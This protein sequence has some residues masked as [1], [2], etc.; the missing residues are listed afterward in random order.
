MPHIHNL[1]FKDEKEVIQFIRDNMT[2]KPWLVQ[3]RKDSKLL[4]ALVLGEDFK[5]VLIKKIEQL[6]SQPRSIARKRYSKDIRD[7]FERVMQPRDNIF[8][9]SGGS[10]H[11][12]VD[13]TKQKERFIETLAKFKGQKGIKKYLADNYFEMV[14]TD[15]NGLIFLEYIDDQKIFPTYKSIHDIRYYV[16]DGQLL[17]VLLFEPKNVTMQGNATTFKRWRV[18]DQEKD[19]SILQSG[20]TFR[21]EEE[22]TFEHPFGEIPGVIL[23]DRTKTGSE[24][25]YSPLFSI[26]PLS[27]DYARDKSIKT[28]YK[29]QHGF[30]LHWRYSQPC[31]HCHGSGKTGEDTC[32]VCDGKGRIL[33][34]DVTDIIEVDLPEDKEDAIVAPNL[35]GFIQP[36]LETWRQYNTDM[37]QDE[38]R[39]EDTMWGTHR[40]REGSG[41]ET[42]TGRFIDIQPVKN[43]LDKMSDTVELIHNQLGDWVINWLFGAPQEEDMYHFAYGRRFIIESAD[44]AMERYIEAMKDGANNTVLDKLLDEYLETNFQN[45]P[46]M[47]A[48]VTKKRNVEPYLHQTI[49]QV[50]I[51]FGAK[52]ASKKVLF[53]KFWER[54]DKSKSLEELETDWEKFLEDNMPEIP[55]P[56]PSPGGSGH[57]DE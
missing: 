1:P 44:T 47:L 7:M 14:D 20:D 10:V 23:S 35:G 25:R 50:N 15:P 49:D 3:A 46:I 13:S 12:K 24:L 48:K 27:E 45:D 9:A 16:S 26:T 18:V 40:V 30:P 19:W 52:E 11:I 38:Q 43:R 55:E 36:D 29:F 21:L 41:R 56:E 32:E 17:K 54:A 53:E 5:N 33:R 8:S 6:E 39:M 51:I 57:L 37:V 2:V 4:R 42:A 34:K 28:I 31:R 22:R